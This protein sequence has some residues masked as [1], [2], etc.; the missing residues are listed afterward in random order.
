[1]AGYGDRDQPDWKGIE[2]MDDRLWWVY[3]ESSKRNNPPETALVLH[4]QSDFAKQH[5]RDDQETITNLMLNRL[6][7]IIGDWAAQPDWVETSQWRYML[8][9]NPMED[10]FI[11]LEMEEAPLAL[12]GD[13]LGGDTVESAYLSGLKLANHWIE[14]YKNEP[15]DTNHA[16]PLL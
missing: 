10:P 15:T 11:E 8:A 2:F 16:K 1:M 6:G 7:E 3:N 12:V 5:K 13:Y 4:S 9:R 14:K